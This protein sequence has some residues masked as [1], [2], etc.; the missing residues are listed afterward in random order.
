MSPL[1]RLWLI[2]ALMCVLPASAVAAPVGERVEAWPNSGRIVFRV[3]YGNDGLR[4]GQTVHEWS[5]DAQRYQMRSLVETAGLAAL[6]KRF[7][8]EQKSEG[9]V[10]AKGLKPR[11]F[12]ADQRGKPFQS[13]RF[14][15]SAGRVFIDRGDSTREAK[16][17]VGD[18]DVLSIMHQLPRLSL[19]GIERK[20]TL[21]NNKAASVSELKDLGVET[22]EL[23]LGTLRTRHLAVKSLDGGVSL[24]LWL[25]LDRHLL[26]VRV[27]MTDRK[28][29]VLDQQAERIELGTGQPAS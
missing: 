16:I 13:A 8:L 26:P 19:A 14:D 25:A 23:P 21:I 3:Y 2:L 11:L 12:T 17:E 4:L 29:E 6:I 22:V 24:D 20:L 10:G 9:T 18:Q 27:R 7:R 1:C 28:G 15:W 5:H